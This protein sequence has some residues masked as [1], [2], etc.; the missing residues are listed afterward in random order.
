MS[1]QIFPIPDSPLTGEMIS[2]A[3]LRPVFL[4]EKDE[5]LTRVS[6]M[7]SRFTRVL[8]P[9]RSVDPTH[10]PNGTT[11]VQELTGQ[12]RVPDVIV[13]YTFIR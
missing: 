8:E 4:T 5:I 6:G 3:R 10:V 13:P 9:Y 2:A 1:H 11:Y 12:T 7:F